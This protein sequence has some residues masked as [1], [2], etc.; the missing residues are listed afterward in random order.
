MGSSRRSLG[1]GALRLIENLGGE[2]MKAKATFLCLLLLSL[3]AQAT[4]AAVPWTEG[5]QYSRIQP[6]QLTGL[7]PG[8]VEVTEVF[9]YGCPYCNAFVPT[10][11]ALKDSL[12]SNAQMDYLPASFSPAED[13]PMF[14]RAFF[15]AK[16]LGVAERMHDA[17]FDAVWKTGDLAVVNLRTHE[18]RHPLPSMADV[19]AFYQ[20][21]T[22]IPAPKFIATAQS[23]WVDSQISNCE[24][25]LR[26]YLVEETPCIIVN[27]K[28]R[29]NMQALRS[30]GE[31]I[32]LVDWLVV[33]E[34]HS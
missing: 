26:A 12:P 9:S 15:T 11:D 3:T 10:A 6:A 33:Q 16:A 1:V 29:V 4:A 21:K 19:A 22:G 20:R 14:Q 8:K 34:S 2:E 28:Y 7:P 27:G 25:L 5:V 31:L 24:R 17:M 23:F 30:P 18:L 13:F 32:R